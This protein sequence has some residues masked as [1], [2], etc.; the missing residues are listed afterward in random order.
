MVRERWFWP[1]ILASM[2]YQSSFA[3]WLPFSW[4]AHVARQ[5]GVWWWW[6][7]NIWLFFFS[8][9]VH[10]ADR[11]CATKEGCTLSGGVWSHQHFSPSPSPQGVFSL[12]GLNLIS[13][14]VTPVFSPPFLL[15]H[16]R[17]YN[18]TRNG[19]FKTLPTCPAQPPFMSDSNTGM[20]EL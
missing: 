11:D 16:C 12:S 15:A 2:V 7:K 4:E 9:E 3:T 13:A 20:G 17:W 5:D 19:Y 10:V 18:R 14:T 6:E 8:P 1:S